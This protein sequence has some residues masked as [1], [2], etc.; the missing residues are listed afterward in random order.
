MIDPNVWIAGLISPLGAPAAVVRA[1]GEGELTAVVTEQILDELAVV[2][3]RS[4]FRRWIS[5]DD[6]VAFVEALRGEADVL[7]DPNV[8]GRRV[9]DP[10]DDYLVAVALAA[11]ATI[12]TGDSDLL[13]AGLEPPAVTPRQLLDRLARP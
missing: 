1:V 11:G 12:V 6:A 3:A 2:L 9:R 5:L 10:D 13:E 8:V 4:K 7:P